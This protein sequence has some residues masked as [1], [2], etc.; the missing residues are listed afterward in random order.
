MGN[1]YSL[2]FWQAAAPQVTHVLGYEKAE[3]KVELRR[4]GA[5][6]T[7]H[8][9]R[10]GKREG[11]KRSK[12]QRKFERKEENVAEGPRKSDVLENAAALI[13][14]QAPKLHGHTPC[15]NPRSKKPSNQPTRQ[16]GSR[17]KVRCFRLGS[18]PVLSHSDTWVQGLGFSKCSPHFNKPPRN[19][20]IQIPERNYKSPVIAKS[21]LPKRKNSGRA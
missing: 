20:K 13:Q 12:Q 5:S 1:V 21:N 7:K 9:K 17:S 4:G 16:P 3:S 19:C 15:S 6:K 14:D 11:K 8:R 18:R 10:G 2:S